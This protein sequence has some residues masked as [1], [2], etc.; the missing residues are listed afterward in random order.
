M[1]AGERLAIA[2]GISSP[3]PDDAD[4]MALACY[5]H[6]MDHVGVMAGG[7]VFRWL[8]RVVLDLHFDACSFQRDKDPG[9]YRRSGVEV[10]GPGG[11]PPAYVGPPHEH[12]P[13]L[14]GEI[15]AWL[16]GSRA[17]ATSRTATRR[18]GSGS[19]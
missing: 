13:A 10:T 1:P 8:D 15:V 11:G 16:E 17:A 3:A 19:A 4:R 18:P 14:V 9:R 7:P 12:L 5:A 6:A 2:S